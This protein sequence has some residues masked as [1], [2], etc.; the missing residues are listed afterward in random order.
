MEAMVFTDPSHN[1][2]KW[3]L[4]LYLLVLKKKCVYVAFFLLP[5]PPPL[6]LKEEIS[7]TI[8]DCACKHNRHI[9]VGNMCELIGV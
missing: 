3:F 2:T 1:Q 4:P 8:M 5:I 9:S 7:S 6:F